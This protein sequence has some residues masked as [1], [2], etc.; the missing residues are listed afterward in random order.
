[1]IKEFL[2]VCTDPIYRPAFRI[3]KKLLLEVVMLDH[4]H[5]THLMCKATSRMSQKMLR[6]Q[7][8]TRTWGYRGEKKNEWALVRLG[9]LAVERN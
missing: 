7:L 5:E 2:K 1:M 8:V 9:A 6:R 4:D 3:S